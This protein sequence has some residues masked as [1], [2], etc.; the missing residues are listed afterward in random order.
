MTRYYSNRRLTIIFAFLVALLPSLTLA[1]L[2]PRPGPSTSSAEA[3]S[4]SGAGKPIGGY[5]A[6]RM[7]TASEGLWTVV[8][9]QDQTGA[10][11]DIDGWRGMLDGGR[12]KVWWI[13]PA[14]F[15]KGPF[16]WAV[17][18]EQNGQLLTSSSSFDLPRAAY[19]T[20]S[21]EIESLSDAPISQ[22]GKS[23]VSQQPL[24]GAAATSTPDFLPVTGAEPEIV[25]VSKLALVWGVLLALISRAINALHKEI[26]EQ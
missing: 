21:A 18:R 25:S 17:Y 12:Q 15:G 8:Q 5:I 19:E 10:W 16:R 6:L 14:D 11:H 9:W 13:D 2:P 24:P 23:P 7:P 3:G 22:R 1:D 26:E 4:D 20:V